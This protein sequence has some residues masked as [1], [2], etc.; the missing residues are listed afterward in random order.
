MPRNRNEK[1]IINFDKAYYSM[2]ILIFITKLYK[3]NFLM[4]KLNWNSF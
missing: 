4:L 1:N 3:N 2:Q